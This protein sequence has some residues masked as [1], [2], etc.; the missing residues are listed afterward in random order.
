M[1]LFEPSSHQRSHLKGR[2]EL[3]LTQA[4]RVSARSP[5]SQ[6]QWWEGAV[7][8]PRSLA[9]EPRGWQA[10]FTVRLRETKGGLL[11]LSTELSW[12]PSLLTP[13]GFS[14]LP[15]SDLTTQHGRNGLSEVPDLKHGGLFSR[16]PEGCLYSAHIPPGPGGYGSWSEQV[17][18]HFPSP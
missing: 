18:Y 12:N 11:D 9:E 6:G 15:A 2:K 4:L 10:H 16:D 1:I 7:F 17:Q 13:L 8:S 14:P 3:W 5:G